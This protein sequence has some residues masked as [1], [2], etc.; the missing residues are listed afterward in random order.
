MRFSQNPLGFILLFVILISAPAQTPSQESTIKIDTTLVSVPVVVSDRQGRYVA[1]LKQEDFTIYQ[2]RIKQSVAFFAATE[3]PINVA[4]LLDTSRSTREVLDD[5]KKAAITLLKQIRP[6]DSLMVIAFD[7]D[8][9]VLCPLTTD[10]KALER[11]VKKAE[12]GQFFGTTL[13]DAVT[14]VIARSFKSVKGRKAIILLTDG[15][16]VGSKVDP[17]EL[18]ASAEE[19]DTLIYPIFYTTS[20]MKRR[21]LAFG[22]RRMDRRNERAEEFLERLAEISSGRFY[23]GEVTDL[24]AT[25]DLILEELRHQYRLGFYPETAEQEGTL[26]RLRVEVNRT[27]VVVR[28]RHSYRS[29]RSDTP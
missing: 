16:D 22:G 3:E 6:Q 14:E 9:H 29:K 23:P 27:E 17:R 7:Y 12:I 8:V 2:D 4:L 20:P 13:N 28:A 5:I 15:K 11:A 26:H 19:A 25:F 1:N 18:L 10:R 21:R 24:K